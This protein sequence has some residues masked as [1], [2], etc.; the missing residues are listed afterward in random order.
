MIENIVLSLYSKPGESPVFKTALDFMP[1]WLGDRKKAVKKQSVEE[2]KML[3]RSI[4]KRQNKKIERE[5][6]LKTHTKTK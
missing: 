3:F 4:A 2:I 6:R 5:S 1:D